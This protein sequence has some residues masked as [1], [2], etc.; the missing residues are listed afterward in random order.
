MFQNEPQ[1]IQLNNESVRV[2]TRA[3]APA[4]VFVPACLFMRVCVCVCRRPCVCVFVCV[5]MC[6]RVRVFVRACVRPCECVCVCL[7]ARVCACD[8]Y[9]RARVCVRACV[10]ARVRARMCECARM[11]VHVCAC[12]WRHN[13]WYSPLWKMTCNT[14]VVLSA[15][16]KICKPYCM[17]VFCLSVST[18]ISTVHPGPVGQLVNVSYDTEHFLNQ[19]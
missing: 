14:C 2:R 4:C 9:A 11:R 6:A 19:F 7:C 13:V 15:L 1:T 17:I 12:A 8:F 16:I 18:R 3:R 10:C 5:C